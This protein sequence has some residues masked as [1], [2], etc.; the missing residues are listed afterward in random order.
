MYINIPSMQTVEARPHK[1]SLFV[2]RHGYISIS[3]CTD[4]PSPK[5]GQCYLSIYIY[6]NT[7]I[8]TYMYMNTSVRALFL[9]LYERTPCAADGCSFWRIRLPHSPT[10]LYIY[11]YIQNIYIYIYIHIYLHNIYKHTQCAADGCWFRQTLL[12]RSPT[13]LYIYMPINN[14]YTHT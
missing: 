3:I 9:G 2:V 7:D 10:W 11:I 4:S 6:I 12:L 13:W 14:E 5:S 8:H 1:L